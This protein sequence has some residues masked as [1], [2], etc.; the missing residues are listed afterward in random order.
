MAEFRQQ[1]ASWIEDYALFMAIKEHFGG[2]SWQDW[3]DE[4][5]LSDAQGRCPQALPEGDGG[6]D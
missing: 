2:I 6:E 5:I 1:Q 3:P 4:A